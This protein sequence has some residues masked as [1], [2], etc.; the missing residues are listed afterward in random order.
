MKAAKLPN[1]KTIRLFL[2]ALQLGILL[3]Q[4]FQAE[5]RKLY[6]NLGF[7]AFSLALVDGSLAVFWMADPLAG[8][9]SALSGGFFE[10]SFRDSELLAAAGAKLCGV[11]DR[12]VGLGGSRGTAAG[13]RPAGQPRAAL[14]TGSLPG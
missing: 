4:L 11:F 6:S 5:A 2:G 8:T 13:L 1:Y 10:R 7:F 12:V 9:E 14:P 3:D